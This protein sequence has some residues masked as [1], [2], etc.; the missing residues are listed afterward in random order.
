[1]LRNWETIDESV[2]QSKFHGM[3]VLGFAPSKD[4]F[5]VT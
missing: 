3:S 5:P 1:M 2:S 4:G